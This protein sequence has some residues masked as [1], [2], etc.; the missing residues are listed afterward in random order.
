MSKREPVE[1]ITS[2]P[3]TVPSTARYPRTVHEIVELV[4]N[5]WRNFYGAATSFP[6][7]HMD[8]HIGEGWTRKQMLAHITAWHDLTNERLLRF[9]TTREAT[10]L[11]Q[12]EDV[13]N[14][15]VA[16]QAVGRTAGEVLKDMELSYNRLRRQVARLTDDQLMAHDGWAAHIVA[17]NTY[18]HY[19]EH[20]DDVYQPPG[21]ATGGTR[22]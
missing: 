17:G 2:A 20:A 21:Q 19:A 18:E 9:L 1:K 15:R 6:S 8:E 13:I 10:D 3:A 14:A 4:D 11:T 5:G 12:D 16:R 7:E 22:R